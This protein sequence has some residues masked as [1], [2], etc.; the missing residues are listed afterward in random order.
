MARRQFGRVRQLP[1]GRWQARGPS[2]AGELRSLGTYRTKA[3]ASQALAAFETDLSRGHW[4]PKQDPITFADY[5]AQWLETRPLKMRTRESYADHLRL[6]INPTLGPLPV[7]RLTPAVVRAWYADLRRQADAKGR[8]GAVLSHS[9][10]VLRAIL[11]TAVEDELLPR[12]P[13]TIKG[14]GTD[15]AR[16][17]RLPT[18]PEIWAVADAAPPRYRALVWLAAATAL[19]S[20]ELAGLRR[21]DVDL[22]HRQLHVRQTYVEPARG[23]AYFGPPKSD[24]GTRTIALPSVVVPL[25]EEHLMRWSGPGPEGLVFLSDKGQPISRHN[26]RWWRDACADA[27]LPATTHLHDLRHA[28]LT[29]AAQSGATLKELMALAGHSSPRA[30]LVYQHAAEHRAT[31][32]ADAMSRRLE[33][34]TAQTHPA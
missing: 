16:E 28:G 25:L 17:R 29:L 33:R 4:V 14:A 26:R 7:S 1:S 8:G 22:L 23:P 19:R 12:N 11:T 30:A 31:A 34:P 20:A 18:E 6:R 27:G 9:Y 21:C 13:C 3:E 15:K 24:A 2:P 5:A 10:R 32:L